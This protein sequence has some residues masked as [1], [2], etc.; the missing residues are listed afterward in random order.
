MEM[1]SVEL[2]V[3]F[4]E[5]LH[6]L[7]NSAI[8]RSVDMIDKLAECV[9]KQ[10]EDNKYQAS[11]YRNDRNETIH[12]F[13]TIKN[14][15]NTGL[16]FSKD[17]LVQHTNLSKKRIYPYPNYSGIVISIPEDLSDYNL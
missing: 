3:L 4:Q 6:F 9:M 14:F 13:K 5:I 7:D 15:K 2:D 16:S 11:K 17:H 1:I 8:D 10:L 12:Y